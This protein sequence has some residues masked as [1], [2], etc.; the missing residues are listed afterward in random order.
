MSKKW[1]LKENGLCFIKA[2]VLPG[3]AGLLPGICLAV[4][5]RHKRPYLVSYECEILVFGQ[6]TTQRVRNCFALD[7]LE[8]RTA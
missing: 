3:V 7:E 8:Q 6:K 1:V 4:D 2:G 5:L